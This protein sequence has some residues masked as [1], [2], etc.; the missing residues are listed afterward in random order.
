MSKKIRV[1]LAVLVALIL[2]TSAL[3]IGVAAIDNEPA[4]EINAANVSFESTVHLWYCVGYENID[5]PEDIKLLV[6]RESAVTDIKNCTKGTESAVLS[7]VEDVNEDGLVG[8]AFDYDDLSAAEMTETVYARAYIELDGKVVYSP[9]VKYSILQYALNK[10]GVTGTATENA[11]LAETLEAMLVYGAAS[12]KL[13]DT[14]LDR[15]A[16]KNYVKITTDVGAFADGSTTGLYQIGEEVKVYASASDDKPYVEWTDANGKLVGSGTEYTFYAN[17]NIQLNATTTDVATSFGAYQHVVIIGV[18]GAGTFFKDS[19]ETPYID[20]IFANGA[21]TYAAE[22]PSPTSSGPSWMSTLHGVPVENHGIND[23]ALVEGTTL[24]P[25]SNAKYPS[26]LKVVKENNPNADV[27]AFYGWQAFDNIIEANANVLKTGPA[28]ANQEMADEKTVTDAVAYIGANKPEALFV[29]LGNVDT[30]GHNQGFGTADYFAAIEAVDAQIKQIYDAYAAA[31]ILDNTLFIVTADHG[32]VFKAGVGDVTNT[33]HGG[34]TAEERY[35]M[36]A[37]AGK[38]VAKNSTIGEMY[39]RDTAAI[40][41]YALGVAAPDTYTGIVPAGLFEGVEATERKTYNDPDSS[42]YH[43]TADTP[44][45]AKDKIESVVGNKLTAYL[46]FDGSIAESV[47]NTQTGSVGTIDFVDGYFGKAANFSDGHM[48]LYNF[49]PGTSSFTISMWMKVPAAVRES[50]ILSNKAKGSRLNGIDF[51]LVRDTDQSWH[52]AKFNLGYNN[53]GTGEDYDILNTE[54]PKDY[55][56]G[57]THVLLIVDRE[58]NTFSTVFDFG[59]L[60]TCDIKAE[61]VDATL[62]AYQLYIGTDANNTQKYPKTD[63]S[64]DEFMVFDGAISR[65]DINDLCEYYGKNPTVADEPTVLDVLNKDNAVYLDFDKNTDN[66]G[67][68]STAVNTYG[69]VNYT[70]GV[71]GNALELGKDNAYLQLPEYKIGTDSF[72]FAC[73]VK[74]TD[75]FVAPSGSNNN[76]YIPLFSNMTAY[77]GKGD[78]MSFILDYRAQHP[79]YVPPCEEYPNGYMWTSCQMYFFNASDTSTRLSKTSPFND[80]L[81]NHEWTHIAFTIDRATST[82]SL[83]INFE[84]AFESPM[85]EYYGNG[86]YTADLDGSDGNYFTIG[87]FSNGTYVTPPELHIDEVVILKDA[88]TDADIAAMAEFYGVN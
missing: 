27:A 75:L 57:W 56:Y 13:F 76:E 28:Y 19:T 51:S 37:A 38:T 11:E 84:K 42:R 66:Q 83:Y 70:A 25:Y 24:T 59:E 3:V 58:N 39:N 6:W 21:V 43:E 22:I 53:T 85:N 45:N 1:I 18:D 73:W 31:G 29:H 8:K 63:L 41:L 72:S 23:N 26:F 46:P 12:Q 69:N 82:Y 62:S 47:N 33:T 67:T 54:L 80:S 44:D 87:Q 9:V 68:A 32:G 77:A 34:L 14:N 55:Q 40:A 5:S 65:N 64:V 86:T 48:L 10:L 2:A 49:T 52:Q 30:V 60:I 50:T 61:Y 36:F 78:G 15:L 16:S 88:L 81:L 71:K 74:T 20:S 79:N 7:S 35:V 17:K 4:L